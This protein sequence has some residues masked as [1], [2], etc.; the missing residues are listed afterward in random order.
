MELY[1]TDDPIIQCSNCGQQYKI[2]RDD[3]DYDNYF[4]GEFGMG[5][6][7]EHDFRFEGTCRHCGSQ[8]FFT[9]SG[10]FGCFLACL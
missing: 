2:S 7:F 5:A 1:L 3:L 8:F 6:R 9:L 4:I 10:F